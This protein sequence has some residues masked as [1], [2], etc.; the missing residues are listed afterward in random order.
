M[1][2]NK[3]KAVQT[4]IEMMMTRKADLSDNELRL[5]SRAG[6]ELTSFAPL[7]VD[8][9]Q[10]ELYRRC[11]NDLDEEASFRWVEGDTEQEEQNND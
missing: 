5:I 8:S 4:V 11:P 9:A 10:T 7:A 3:A 6:R 1:T 2:D